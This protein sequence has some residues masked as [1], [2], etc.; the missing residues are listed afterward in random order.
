MRIVF[1]CSLIC[2]SNSVSIDNVLS[3]LVGFSKKITNKSFV[4]G[5]ANVA[6][7]RDL[8]KVIMDHK[9]DPTYLLSMLSNVDPTQLN[10]VIVLVRSL[11]A[12]SEADLA[13]L[14]LVSTNANTAYTDATAAYDASVLAKVNLQREKTNLETDLAAKSAE[15][16]QQVIVVAGALTSQTEAHGAMTNAQDTLNTETTRLNGEI[17]TLKQVIALLEGLAGSS[18]VDKAY[19]HWK[20][21]VTD[22]A[23]NNY[24]CMGN[25]F[26]VD[27]N[28]D[29]IDVSGS[30]Y[31]ADSCGNDGDCSRAGNYGAG[32]AFVG[33]STGDDYCS[34]WSVNK[35]WLSI[36][37]PTA[38]APV[39]IRME[40]DVKQD[41]PTAFKW[42]ASTNGATW[43]E[44]V[45][46]SGYTWTGPHTFDL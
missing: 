45:L 30:T 33:S 13:A 31:A 44:V 11:L 36:T 21:T 42:T 2:L 8:M 46:Q 15:L 26:F 28:G 7:D 34:N 5:V 14:T 1:L 10:A 4:T 16:E 32:S 43:V 12:A 37:F 39:A 9:K 29:N 18:V 27:K 40:P 41:C 25:I 19:S 20:L 22:N 6:K 35:G 23:N 24:W 38:V 3:P 17:S